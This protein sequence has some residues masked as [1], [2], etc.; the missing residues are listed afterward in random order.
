MRK[1]LI[2]LVFMIIWAALTAFVLLAGITYNLPDFVHVDYGFPLSWA[3]HTLSTI[4]G[5][6]DQWSVSL[7]NLLIDQLFWFAIMIVV[8]SGLLYKL[9]T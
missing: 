3:T 2:V 7:S 1:I 4:A 9:R 5:P 6:A 8:V